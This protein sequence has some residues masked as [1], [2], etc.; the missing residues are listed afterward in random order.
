MRLKGRLG[1]IPVMHVQS[2]SALELSI[3]GQ[4]RPESSSI[5]GEARKTDA[6]GSKVLMLQKATELANTCMKDY[7]ILTSLHW[8]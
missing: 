1:K 4:L 3:G 8:I 5:R 6:L 2:K 7:G